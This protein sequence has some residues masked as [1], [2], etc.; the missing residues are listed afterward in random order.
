MKLFGGGRYSRSRVRNLRVTVCT[1]DD[2][3]NAKLAIDSRMGTLLDETTYVLGVAISSGLAK[4]EAVSWLV[5][6]SRLTTCTPEDGT[7]VRAATSAVVFDRTG[8]NAR[9]KS[10]MLYS[11]RSGGM[12]S[13]R[14]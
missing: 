1:W 11:S 12:S 9:P 7:G 8:P 5:I 13:Q 3:S 2:E 10:S 6:K 14:G 4:E